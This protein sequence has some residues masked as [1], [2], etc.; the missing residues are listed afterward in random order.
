MVGIVNKVYYLCPTLVG[1][2]LFRVYTVLRIL[3]R[4]PRAG[5]ARGTETRTHRIW[6]TSF[7]LVIT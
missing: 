1:A 6:L 5:S 3:W 7:R 4:F 2:A